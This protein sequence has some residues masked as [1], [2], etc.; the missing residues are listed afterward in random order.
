MD[1]RGI[2]AFTSQIWRAGNLKREITFN[3]TNLNHLRVQD[4]P[5][6][7]GTAIMDITRR[8]NRNKDLQIRPGLCEEMQD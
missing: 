5:Q 4:P 7:C 8:E 3:F 1:T 2:K 6:Y